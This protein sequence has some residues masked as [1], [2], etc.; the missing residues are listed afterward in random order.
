MKVRVFL[1]GPALAAMSLAQSAPANQPVAETAPAAASSA[2]V[3]GLLERVNKTAQSMQANLSAMR[4]DRW[5]TDTNTKRSTEG[6][7]DSLQ[8]NLKDALPEIM[9]QL[10][11][12][13]DSLPATFKLYRNLDALYDVFSS[14]TESAGAFG[15]RDDYQALANDLD[16]LEKTRRALAERMDALSTS[17]E[18]EITALHVQLHDAQAKLAEAPPPPKKVVDDNEAPPAPKPVKKKPK[19]P[20]PPSATPSQTQTQSQTTDSQTGSQPNPQQPQSH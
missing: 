10:R 7:V 17:K 18:S 15:S 12:A 9:S 4:I 8:R 2:Q 20:K 5:K 11:N 13:P 19:V 6:D 3:N 16:D 14:V 1:L